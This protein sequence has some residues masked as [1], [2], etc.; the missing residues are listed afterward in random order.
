M[1][2][3]VVD[4]IVICVY[5]GISIAIGLYVSRNKSAESYFLGGR[6]FAGW[7]IGI[8]FIGAMVSSV[9]FIAMP[10]DSFKTAWARILPGFG[11]PIVAL[12]SAYFFV[13]FFRRGTI[14]SAYRYLGLRF[15]NWISLYG[16]VIYLLSQVIRT[17]IITYLVAVLISPL[18]GI[19]IEWCILIA[20]GVT[21]VYTIKGGFAAVIWTDVIQTVIIVFGSLI[22]VWVIV[23]AI[24]G[25]LGQVWSEAN[26]AGK[27]SLSDLNTSTG[28]LEPVARGFSLSEKTLTMLIIVGVMQFLAGKLNQESVQR[29]C[30]AKTA[31][32]ARKSMFVV[33]IFAIP[34]WAAFMFIG[35]CLWV[36]YKTF[37]DVTANAVLDGTRKAEEILPYFIATALPP[38]IAGM[39]ISAALAAAMSSLSSAINSTSMVCVNDIYKAH[40]VKGASDRHYL[41]AGLLSS[42]GVSLIMIGGAYLFHL[43]DSKTLADFSIIIISLLGGG[44][45]AVFL[46]GML[47][48]RA[49]QRSVLVGVAVTLT[50]TVY[51]LLGQF[52]LIPLPFD[53]YYTSIF[54]TC[55]MF[56]VGYLSAF[57]FSREPRDLENLT[58]WDQTK[59]EL[60]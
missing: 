21:S 19:G 51:A 28:Q 48:R 5:F 7:A 10:A 17:A 18:T 34:I 22:C 44:L 6:S 41:R 26:E 36:Y 9:T 53:S 47:T 16:A 45:P 4:I 43:T 25:G 46:L 54:S 29:W 12:V 58:L 3:Q 37:P 1:K 35:T 52:K 23:S 49:D 11:F 56:V 31:H 2:L 14:T 55:I 30:A 8:S 59:D 24:P 38:G 20:G 60:V 33:G 50:F 40:F 42:L 32:E 13:P 57:A 15:G 27:F 39:L